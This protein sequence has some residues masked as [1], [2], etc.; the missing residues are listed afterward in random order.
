MMLDALPMSRR[1]L[2]ARRL[3]EGRALVAAT[4]A[5]EFGVSEDAIRRDLRAL[6]AEGLCKRVYGGA[7]PLSPASAPVSERITQDPAR[8]RALARAAVPLIQRRETV[9]LDCGSTN[10]ALAAELPA[11]RD[12]TVVTNAVP[13]AAAL[14]GRP[15]VRLVV[16]GGSVDPAVG[17]CVDARAVLDLQTFQVDRCFL[18]ACAI[19][20]E[21]GAAS[22]DFADAVFKRTLLSVSRSVAVLATGDKLGT[23]AP[24]RIAA[25]AEFDDLV[26]EHDTASA[27]RDA[28]AEA[29]AT[30]RLAE[31][32]PS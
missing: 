12:L 4:L 30:L 6:A 2:I 8:K 11:D 1:D 7:L 29:G 9:F 28:L 24:H 21:L 17:G 23:R 15:G 19:S 14:L 3:A 22:F 32:S 13:I 5:A 16:V 10:L 26:V 18:G 31:P 25:L 27:M 20:A